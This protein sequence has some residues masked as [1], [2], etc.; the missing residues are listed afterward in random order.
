MTI[1]PSD[2]QILELPENSTVTVY[3][4]C[5]TIGSHTLTWISEQHIGGNGEEYGFATAHSVG[6]QRP[7]TVN[8]MTPS[9]AILTGRY[10]HG[11]EWVLESTLKVYV[12]MRAGVSNVSC[13]HEDETAKTIAIIVKGN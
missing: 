2:D 4:H 13:V 11:G 5:Q 8:K 10:N 3:L 6:T 7:V 9:V 1:E 12:S